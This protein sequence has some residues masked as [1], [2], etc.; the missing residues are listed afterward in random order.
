MISNCLLHQ[1]EILRIRVE[2]DDLAL[3]HL[4]RVGIVL[5]ATVRSLFH[6]GLRRVAYL[7]SGLI[8]TFVQGRPHF[9]VLTALLLHVIVLL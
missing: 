1:L 7:H 9:L 5:F 2:A 4:T 3:F 6:P 8:N